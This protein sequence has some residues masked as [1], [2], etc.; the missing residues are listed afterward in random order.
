[1]SPFPSFLYSQLLTTLP[2]PTASF[3]GKTVIVTGS[4]TGLGLEAARHFARLGAA[5]LILAVRSLDKGHAAKA[6]I[7]ASTHCPPG[8]ISVWKLDMASYTSVQ[9]FAAR[10]AAELDRLDVAVLNAGIATATY[11]RCAEADAELTLVVNVVS[12]LLLALLLLPQLQRT[13]AKHASLPNLVVVSSEVHGFTSFA[14]KSAPEGELFATLN[15]PAA[16]DM[17]DRYNVSKLLEVFA[18]RAL[19][20]RHPAEEL[21]VVVNYV[22]PGLCHSELARDSGWGL[23]A[24]KQLLART[25]EAGSRTLVHAATVGAEAHG[26]YMSDCAVAQPSP[27]VRSEVGAEVQERVWEELSAILEGIVPGVTEL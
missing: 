25:T 3:A 24:M 10:A 22:N 15:D 26:Q 2:P 14:E 16:A 9:S 5:K 6:S 23:W 13:A 27:L 21:G 19:A 20:A 1:M 17:R 12:T 7:E 4:N 18:V 11:Q 8:T